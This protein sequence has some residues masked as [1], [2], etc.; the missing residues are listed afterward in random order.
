MGAGAAGSMGFVH[1]N[2]RLAAADYIGRRWYFVTMC[3][4]DRRPTFANPV[5]A[6]GFV[7]TLRARSAASHFAVYAYCV[8]PDHVH[9]LLGGLEATS[10]LLAFVA[11]LKRETSYEFRRRFDGVL[12]QKKFYDYILRS[13]DSAERVAGYIWMNPVR[14]GLRRDPREYPHSGSFVV[15]WKGADSAGDAWVPSWKA[16]GGGPP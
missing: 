13:K 6:S 3:C 11:D 14:A 8:M 1:K 5:N 4:A 7:D 16:K 10:N 2:I 9:V 12:W 15:D